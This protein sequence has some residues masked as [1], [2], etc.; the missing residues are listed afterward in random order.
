MYNGKIKRKGIGSMDDL[1]K[2]L[3]MEEDTPIPA[4]YKIPYFVHQDDM[5][6]LEQNHKRIEKWLIAFCIILFVAFVG[7]NAWWMWYENQ[8]E[9]IT[10]TVTQETS[11]EGGGDAILNGDNAGAVFYGEGE[12]NSNNEG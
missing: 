9:D 1:K 4:D 6:R 3:G 8:F 11:S 10:T 7:T 2:N 12:T 5:N